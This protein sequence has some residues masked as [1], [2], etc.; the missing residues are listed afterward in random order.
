MR[1]PYTPIV[2]S[3]AYKTSFTLQVQSAGRRPPY[4][5]VSGEEPAVR[6]RHCVGL[7]AF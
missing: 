7:V 4:C 1:I 6:R 5:S 2:L 3:G